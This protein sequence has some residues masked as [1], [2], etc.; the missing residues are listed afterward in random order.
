MEPKI[1]MIGRTQEVIDILI[2][3][4][5]PF[6]RSIVGSNDKEIIKKLLEKEN[7]DFVVIGAGLPDEVRDEMKG[8]LLSIKSNLT[9][10]LIER[11]EKGSP[12]KLIEFTNQKAVEWKVGQKLG[13]RPVEKKD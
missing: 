3:E 11:T 10:N 7:I 9:V 4:L 6:G 13:K 1:L 2:E 8:F 5:K 12:Y